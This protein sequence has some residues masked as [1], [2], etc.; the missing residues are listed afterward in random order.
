M[1]KIIFYFSGTGNSYYVAKS[2]ANSIDAQLEPTAAYGLLDELF[3]HVDIIGI[4]FP[5]YHQGVPNGVKDFI[6]KIKNLKNKYIFAV[7]TYGDHPC[8]SLE[9]LDKLLNK[10]N[11]YLSC[12]FSIQMPYNY[13]SPTFRVK[14]FFKSF[15]LRNLTM[16]E[17]EKVYKVSK[18]KI[19]KISRYVNEGKEGIIEKDAVMIEK[20]IDYLNLRNTLQKKVWLKVAGYSGGSNISFDQAIKFMDH[21]FNVNSNCNACGLCK[22]ICPVQNISLENN[23]PQWN[24]ICEQCFAC[25]HWCP[26]E[27]INFREGTVNC[28]R[29]THPEVKASDLIFKLKE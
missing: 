26:Q 14:D 6:K 25:L 27:A 5:V 20:I 17:R 8:L 10:K 22:K 4:V 24:H 19:D 12:G 29:Y 28:Q 23:Q 18:N 11:A 7:C 3:F 9:Y 1:K 21:G 15:G 13:I 2:I 16:D